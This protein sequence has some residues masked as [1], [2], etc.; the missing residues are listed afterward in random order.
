[1]GSNIY[2]IVYLDMLDI[3]DQYLLYG[4]YYMKQIGVTLQIKHCDIMV[5]YDSISV[6][7]GHANSVLP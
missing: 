6:D 3:N 5:I 1:M 2:L 7:L 4:I